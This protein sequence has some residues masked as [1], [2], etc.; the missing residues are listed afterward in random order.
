MTSSGEFAYLVKVSVGLLVVPVVAVIG[1]IYSGK[2]SSQPPAAATVEPAQAAVP[3]P[4]ARALA[5]IPEGPGR[6]SIHRGYEI[7]SKTFE[8]LPDNVGNGL[9]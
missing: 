9:H 5:A 6:A 7:V 3:D 4:L 2:T 8:T 1:V